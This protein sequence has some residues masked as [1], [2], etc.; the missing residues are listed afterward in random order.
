LRAIITNGVVVA[1]VKRLYNSAM[2]PRRR[3]LLILTVE[4]AACVLLAAGYALVLRPAPAV[5]VTAPAAT[6]PASQTAV[7][8]TSPAVVALP[9]TATLESLTPIVVGSP[10]AVTL[11][12]AVSSDGDDLRLRTEPGPVGLVLGLLMAGTPLTAVGRTPDS[13]WIEVNLDDGRRGWVLAEFVDLPPAAAALPVTGVVITPTP[14]ADGPFINLYAAKARDIFRAGQALGNRANVFALVGDSNTD[15][16]AFL[17]PFDQAHFDLGPYGYLQTTIDFFRG[18]FARHSPAAV[19]SF[20]TTKVLDPAY[21]D[22]RCNGG[23]S[24]LAC[25]YRL[26][27]P[28]VALILLGT[29]DQHA[30]QTFE[31]RYRTIIEYTLQQGIIPV[32]IT[33]A[34]DLEHR[35]NTADSGYINEVIIRLS[36]EYRLPLLDLAAAVAPLPDHGLKAD[37]FHYNSPP[38]GLTGY[39]TGNHLDYGFTVRNLTALQILDVLRQQVLTA[40]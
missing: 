33:K 22:D 38:D 11:R 30:W 35:D 8:S 25:E 31:Q 7:V 16:P 21:A 14:D 39:F 23:E 40:G 37:G 27:R 18:S 36:G 24:P 1:R 12:V 13:A 2:A 15:N 6:G 28:A 32:L 9:A 19:G 3:L 10:T 26:Q 4:A 34:D 29:G 17:Y 5:P 20:N